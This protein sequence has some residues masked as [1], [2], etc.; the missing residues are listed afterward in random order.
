MAGK[1]EFVV[2]IQPGTEG[3]RMERF[4]GAGKGGPEDRP[5]RGPG[6]GAEFCASGTLF[7]CTCKDGSR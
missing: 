6:C 1:E 7:E 3:E 4:G 2:R 5:G